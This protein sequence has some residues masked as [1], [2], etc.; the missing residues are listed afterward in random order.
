MEESQQVSQ[1]QPKPAVQTSR[2]QAATVLRVLPLEHHEPPAFQTH[3][4]PT[5]WHGDMWE[6]SEKTRP[7]RSHLIR[8]MMMAT[9]AARR[10]PPVMVSTILVGLLFPLIRSCTP[11]CTIN[12]ASV[13]TAPVANHQRNVFT[14]PDSMFSAGNLAVLTLK[15]QA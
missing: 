2:V 5:L 3:H 12:T 9:H 1:V 10:P 13:I 8:F 6:S 15:S 4:G 7:M 11:P 14:G